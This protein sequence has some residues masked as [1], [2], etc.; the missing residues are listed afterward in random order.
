MFVTLAE[1]TE[2]SLI[3]GGS[4]EAIDDDNIDGAVFSKQDLSFN[5]AGS[6]TVS[7]PAGHGIVC[8]DDLVVTG[9][10]Y[11]IESASH[12]L[13]YNVFIYSSSQLVSGA[14]YTVSAG[15]VSG[16]TQAN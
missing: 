12:G 7:S 8:K 2:N 11:V 1:G 14:S 6:L 10:S 3:N 15:T 4:F 9:G 5:G 13:D 16:E